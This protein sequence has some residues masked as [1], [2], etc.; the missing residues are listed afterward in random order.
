MLKHALSQMNYKSDAR[1]A[2]V[3]E[4]SLGEIMNNLNDAHNMLLVQG[5]LERAIS[6]M[7]RTILKQ[8]GCDELPS[9]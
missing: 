2:H 7:L 4:E 1:V 6:K 8:E 9:L 5:D 3:S